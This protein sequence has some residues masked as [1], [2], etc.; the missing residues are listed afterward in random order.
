MKIAV[1]TKNRTNPA[2]EAARLGADR[3]ARRLGAQTV[4]FVPERAD[5]PV[6][7]SALIDRALAERADAIVL[8][9]V[10]P[11]RVSAAIDRIHA[12]GVPLFGFVSPIPD[13]RCVSC[14]GADDGALGRGI[15]E[16]LL[17][18]LGGRGR[19][20]LV[21]GPM[22]SVTGAARLHAFQDATA[23]QPGIRVVGTCVGDYA[24]E[25]A[26]DAVA[27]WLATNEG[28]D[29]CLAANDVMALGA[30]DALRTKGRT[31]AVAGVN[32]IPEAIAAIRSGEMLATVDF[33]A[34]RM[35]ALATEC[36]VRHLR[37]EPVPKTIELPAEIVDRHN[38]HLW[39][40]PFAQRPI[41]TLAEVL[42]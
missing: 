39:D 9:P 24:R 30:L 11:T 31:A 22:D 3:A 34:M 23:K 35:A 36:A 38:C 42:A 12:A 26:R 33:S 19:L 13:G 27:R 37:G 21:A 25:V 20:L 41:P 17:A 2:Y 32:A 1:F 5:D 16:Y 40:L 29:A 18:H 6:E 14:V 28:P 7:Q 8:A 15:A 10:H 4:H